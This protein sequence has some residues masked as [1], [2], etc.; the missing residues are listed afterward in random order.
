MGEPIFDRSKRYV[1]KK[2][3]KFG[4]GVWLG[5]NRV[6]QP[7][8]GD[9]D[10]DSRTVTQY[11]TDGTKSVFSW[12]QWQDKK[13]KEHEYKVL[14][15]DR[16]YAIPYIPSKKMTITLDKVKDDKKN[17]RGAT[18]SENLLDSIAVNAKK[19]GLPFSTALGIAA[20]ES[21]IGS[22]PVRTAG[23][24][25]QPI[26]YSMNQNPNMKKAA[27]NIDYQG[28][29]SPSMLI[30]NWKGI[31]ANPF[32]DFQYD[33][34]GDLL[35]TARDNHYYD[36]GFNYALKKSNDYKM[37]EG[38]PLYHGFKF[39]KEHPKEY[40]HGDPGYP[41]KVKKQKEELVNHSPEIKAYMQKHNLHSEGGYMDNLWDSLSMKEK[42]EMMKVAIANGITSL[43]EIKQAYNEFAKGGRMKNW[44]MEDENGYRY[45]RQNLP[46]NLRETNDND[47]DM[48]AAYK[49]GMEPQWSEEDKSYHLRSRDPESGRILKSPH[50]P[51]FLKALVEDA[52]LGYY[53][54]MDSK[55]N[56]Y[57]ETWEGNKYGNG[58][59]APSESI[60]KRITNWEGESMKTNR[61]FAAEAKD[62]NA[63]IPAEVRKKLSS[64]QLDALFSYGYNVGM[65]N[66]KKRVLPALTAY[67]NGKASKEDVQRSMWAS[68][69]NELRGLTTRRNAEREMFGGNYRTTFTGTGKLGVHMDP[70]EFTYYEDLSPM[71]DSIN[72]PQ[73]QLPEGMD[74]DPE[75]KYKAPTIDA[76]LF[77]TPKKEVVE[78]V[79]NPKQERLEGLRNFNTVLGLMGQQSPFAADN[80]STGLLSY[81]SK[82]Y[83]I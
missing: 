48:R 8:W 57:T 28:Y 59:Y 49:A 52:K 33:P 39:Y 20:Q 22:N 73:L 55:G 4:K 17:N 66:L 40:N 46:K 35:K 79:Y 3:Q 26:L 7:G 18:F 44:T 75:L 36:K 53:P 38:S 13:T 41:D 24:G 83:N 29:Y 54:T 27:Q 51:T 19:A 10:R 82:I 76:T 21:T 37:E 69:D 80:G 1:N 12:E 74:T 67:T 15:N 61:S 60:K 23:I 81:I 70:K 62:F 72:I 31:S 2:G 34:Q 32:A 5:Y 64:Q 65:G 45:W 25:L 78:P 43:P 30:S 63:T 42:A 50:H 68:R 14:Q 9:F 71:I 11:N 47:Y 77:Q 6:I 58:G 16:K 56:T